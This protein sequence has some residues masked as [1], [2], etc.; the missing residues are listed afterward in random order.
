MTEKEL[1][2]RLVRH[3]IATQ[4]RTPNGH[5]EANQDT[6]IRA[7]GNAAIANALEFLGKHAVVADVQP[8]FGSAGIGFAYTIAPQLVQDLTTDDAIE[9]RIDALFSGPKTETV[10]PSKNFLSGCERG[11]INPIYRDV[12][13]SLRSESW[14][15][16]FETSVS[17]HVWHCQVSFSRYASK[18]FML[19]RDISFDDNWMI[20]ALLRKIREAAPDKYL[21][22]SLGHIA[23]IINESRIPAVHSR[24][25]YPFRHG[26]RLLWSFT[27]LPILSTECFYIHDNSEASGLTNDGASRSRRLILF[28]LGR[29][30]VSYDCPAN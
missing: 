28:S 11:S 13:Y 26:N 12:I 3:G 27:Q 5:A 25:R 4:R 6:E 2:V 29:S 10:T 1:A 9:S 22:K 30:N 21:D 8:T 19:D 20:G 23:N 18:Q 17:S 16:A 15:S 24:R 7:S 14:T